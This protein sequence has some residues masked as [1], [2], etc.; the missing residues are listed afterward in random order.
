ML[1]RHV[2][3]RWLSLKPAIARLIECWKGV[4][5]YFIAEG[6]EETN[7]LIWKFVGDRENSLLDEE[8]SVPEC[9][10]HFVL[11]FMNIFTQ[12][13]KQLESSTT[14]V[15]QLYDI[16]EG[17]KNELNTRIGDQ[18]FGFAVNNNFKNL[19]ANQ[20]ASFKKD[21][22]NVYTRALTYLQQWFNFEN[23][24]MGKFKIFNLGEVFMFDD[25]LDLINICEITVDGD[26]LYREY[27]ILK[28]CIPKL[29]AVSEIDKR[30]IDFFKKC[31]A[32]ARSQRGGQGGHG[33]P[34]PQPWPPLAPVLAP[35]AL[36]LA[37]PGPTVGPP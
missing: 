27:C 25:L 34:W 14:Y 33:P 9:Y 7:K 18:F 28:Q 30:W 26:I 36:A 19:T 12:A 8:L 3:I 17:V 15:T 24:P 4:K 10:L 23:N 35:L 1:L 21:A 11:S 32:Q 16:M 5:T 37:P 20:I 29:K 2:S 31:D 13:I 22:V 6:K